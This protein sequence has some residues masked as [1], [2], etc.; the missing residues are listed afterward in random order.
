MIKSTKF[1]TPRIGNR[2]EIPYD[3]FVNGG[4]SYGTGQKEHSE[5]HFHLY[6][7]KKNPTFHFSILI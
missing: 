7:N 1:N 2:T 5:P 3:I 6:D 4:D